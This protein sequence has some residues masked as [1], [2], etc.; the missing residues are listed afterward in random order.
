MSILKIKD[1]TGQ[2]M[3]IP[4]IIGAKGDKGEDGLPGANGKDGVDGYTPVKG[5]DYYTEADKAEIVEA[6]ILQ[7]P[8][9]S[10]SYEAGEGIKIENKT[11][12]VVTTDKVEQNN[13]LPITSHGVYTVVGNINALLETI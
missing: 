4:A 2:W 3:D 10:T 1:D 13:T 12:S 7:I 5:V 8:I 9:L 6:V 11:I